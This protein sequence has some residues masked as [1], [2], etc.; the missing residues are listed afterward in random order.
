MSV[1]VSGEEYAA[2]EEGVGIERESPLNIEA[3]ERGGLDF[4]ELRR[5]FEKAGYSTSALAGLTEVERTGGRVDVA[6][7]LRRTAGGTPLENL[8]RLFVLGRPITRLAVTDALPGVPLDALC[9]SGLLKVVDGDT[10]QATMSI[11]PFDDWFITHDRGVEDG[12]PQGKKDVVMGIGVSSIAV[13]RMAVRRRGKSASIWEQ[14]G[15]SAFTASSHVERVTATISI[16][17]PRL[18]SLERQTQWRHEHR[19]SMWQPL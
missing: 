5:A 9:A 19:D 14:F 1:Q 17:G 4:E 12:S 18:R 6:Y 8:V 7:A 10:V 16:R 2:A 13:A 11:L 15:L 3:A